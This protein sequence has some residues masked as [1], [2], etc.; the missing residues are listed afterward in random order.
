MDDQSRLRAILD[1]A[2][3]GVITIDERGLIEAVNPAAETLFGYTA[4]EMIGR[5]VNMLMPSP[6]REEHDGYLSNY[7]RSGEAKI[8]G[9]GREVRGRRKD[10]S[11]FPLYL[12]VSEINFGFR[13][14]FTGFLHDLTALRKAEEQGAELGRILEDSVNE[15]FIF[16]ATTLKF[17]LVNH[18]ALVNMGY[19]AD[20]MYDLTPVDIKPEFTTE[21]FA[22]RI[23]ALST[24]EEQLLQFETVHQRKDGS[25]YDVLVR[26]QKTIW[27]GDDA[28]VAII[29]DV[30]DR[31][32]QETELRIRNRAIQAASEGIVIVDGKQKGHPIVFVNEAFQSIT[33]F[34]F[35][36]AVGRGCDILCEHDSGQSQIQGLKAAVAE[37]QEF[38]ATIE[39]A[40]KDGQLFWNEISIAPVKDR[41]GVV[42]H[43]VAVMEDVTERRRTQQERLQSER[44]AAIGQMVTGLAHESRNALQRAQACLDLLALELEGQPEQLELTTKTHRGMRPSG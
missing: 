14:V 40:R 31:K 32:R 19:T 16:D 18:G 9:I 15:I 21:Q 33:G 26:L 36:E 17:R 39:C 8:I 24:G 5:N 13:R 27:R 22:E 25:H 3:D 41:H 7:Q 43:L 28:Y 42:S 38:H 12:A 29:L 20:E 30:T 35:E 37:H 1:S 44:L 6:F 11:T 2:V 34:S 4:S 23:E 10:G